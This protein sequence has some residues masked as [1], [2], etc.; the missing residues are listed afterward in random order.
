MKVEAGKRV[1]DVVHVVDGVAGAPLFEGLDRAAAGVDAVAFER[2][3]R[4]HDR[5]GDIRDL[6]QA[7]V[8][9]EEGEAELHALLEA[10]AGLGAARHARVGVAIDAHLVAEPAAEHLVDRHAIGLAGEVPERDFDRRDAA[11]LPAVPAELLDAAE[12]PVDVAGVLAEQPALQHQR[13][14]GAGAV[15]HL[16]EPDDALVGVDLEQRRGE[17]RADDFGY[18]HVGD[19]KLGRLRVRVDP[20]ERLVGA[21][22]LWHDLSSFWWRG[23]SPARWAGMERC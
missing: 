20:I 17:R 11:A 8:H 19:A 12:Q 23:L 13:I 15:A 5:A 7:Q 16:A 21:T 14:G 4:G 3:G 6:H 9:L 2:A 18:P 22:R 1:A 10:L